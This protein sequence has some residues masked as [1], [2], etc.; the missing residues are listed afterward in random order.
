MKNWYLKEPDKVT[1][2]DLV[3]AGQMGYDAIIQGG[4]LIKLKKRGK[5]LWQRA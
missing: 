3:L 5:K 2:S 4:K 1:L